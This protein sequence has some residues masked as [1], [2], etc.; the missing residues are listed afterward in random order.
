[1]PPTPKAEASSSK[2]DK[3][4]AWSNIHT[5]ELNDANQPIVIPRGDEVSQADLN[6]SD[7]DWNELRANGVVR[8]QAYPDVPGNYSG[9]PLD[10]LR[11]EAAKA[12]TLQELQEESE[13]E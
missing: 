7:A 4:Y 5:G 1:M 11:E 12:A 2:S 9:S 6:V 13:N 8:K 3:F 10:Y